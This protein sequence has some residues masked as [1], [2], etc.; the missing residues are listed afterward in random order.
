MPFEQTTL[1]EFDDLK[2]VGGVRLRVRLVQ[3]RAEGE[4]LL[5]IRRH[6]ESDTFTGWTKR[7][8]TLTK[9][10]FETLLEQSNNILKEFE[11]EKGKGRSKKER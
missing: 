6:V 4:K 9:E 11:S 8:V 1:K 2:N 7:G 5:D 10:M 3:L